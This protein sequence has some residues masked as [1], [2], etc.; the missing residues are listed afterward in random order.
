MCWVA[1]DRGLRLARDS[2]RRAPERRWRAVRKAIAE[3]V[4][5]QGYDRRR[6]VFVQAF[7]GTQLDAALLLLPSV[8][9]VAYDDERMIRTTE[10]IRTKL[11]VDGLLQRYRG[12]GTVKGREGAFLACSFWL[13]ECLARQ[14]RTEDAHEVFERAAA[15]A[16]D[17]GLFSEQFDPGTAEML[18]NFPQGLTHLSHIMAALALLDADQRA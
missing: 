2:G 13:A 7:G 4:H 17:L 10:A 15:T 8:G 18:G 3:A 16:N 9:F 6:G 1:L 5:R 12:A 14:R 11:S